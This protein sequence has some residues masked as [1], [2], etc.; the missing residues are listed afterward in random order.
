VI[1]R[2]ATS[3]ASAKCILLESRYQPVVEVQIAEK[4]PSGAKAH[5]LLS[6]VC[7]TTKVVPFQKTEFHHGLIVTMVSPARLTT[8]NELNHIPR[9]GLSRLIV[10]LVCTFAA[11]L[12][13][14][15]IGLTVPFTHGTVSPVWPAAGVALA[16][17]LLF[18]YRIWPAVTLAAFTVNYFTGI[19][20]IAAL[21]T[22]LGST[23]GPLFGA[24]LMRRLP[25]FRPSLLRLRDVLGLCI[26]GALC[27]PAV[28]ATIGT[29]VLNLDKVNTQSG[30][31]AAWLTW[32]WGDGTGVLI[33]T[34]FL[35]T[36]A[37]LMRI[38]DKRG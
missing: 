1:L 24:W 27:G 15:K 21:G 36:V 12:L 26:C 20:H 23:A 22:A 4:H 28:S 38:R 14:G 25:S 9:Q 13:A 17:M 8:E 29:A 6:I 19:P 31:A 2:R 35:L 11:C 18:G 34:P 37:G 5:R 10:E 33:V 16:A 30:L 32:W 7:G 3:A